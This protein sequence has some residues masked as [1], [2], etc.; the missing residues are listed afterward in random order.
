MTTQEIVKHWVVMNA[1]IAQMPRKH[2]WAASVTICGYDEVGYGATIERAYR[3]LADELHD[4][5]TC[6]SYIIDNQQQNK[7]K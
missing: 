3:E 2:I 1:K 4:S 7:D 5:N 6:R